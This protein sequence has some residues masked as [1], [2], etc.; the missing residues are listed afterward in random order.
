MFGLRRKNR[1]Q[2]IVL[3]DWDNLM[4]NCKIPSPD[5]LSIIE[6][7]DQLV[8]Q[9]AKV[10][11]ILNIFVF[12]PPQAVNLELED[13][14]KLGIY[15]IPCP[16]IKDKAGQETDTVD[17]T[18]IEFGKKAISQIPNLTHLCLASGDKDFIPLLREAM[19]RG[20][21]II[22]VAGSISSLSAEL[23]PLAD[24]DPATGRKMILTFSPS[25]E[26]NP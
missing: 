17:Q 4:L 1:N 23:I 9:L 6:G 5:R 21:K 10:G 13:F 24:K 22:I 7:F 8:R 16:K 20:L 12:G 25:K 3:A 26:E 18:L 2:I 14:R 11:E 15:A 19:R